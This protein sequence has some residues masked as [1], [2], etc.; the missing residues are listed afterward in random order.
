VS[1]QVGRLAD[2]LVEKRDR[3][4]CHQLDAIRVA[5]DPSVAMEVEQARAEDGTGLT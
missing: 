1:D 4:V 3:V 5:Y 2:G